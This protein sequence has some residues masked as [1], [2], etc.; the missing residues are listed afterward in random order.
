MARASAGSDFPPPESKRTRATSRAGTSTTDSPSVSS[1]WLRPWPRPRA[2]ST[3][4]RRSGHCRAQRSSR[5]CARASTRSWPSSR[6]AGSTARAVCEDL[7]GSTAIK[8]MKALPVVA[9]L[10]W[11]ERWTGRLREHPHASVESHRGR[12]VA[13]DTPPQSQSCS[14]ARQQNLG[15]QPTSVLNT[16]G[17]QPPVSGRIQTSRQNLMRPTDT[18]DANLPAPACCRL[19]GSASAAPAC[20]PPESRAPMTD[21]AASRFGAGRTHQAPASDAVR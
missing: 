13:G 8:I 9:E 12:T 11:G 1:H 21:A 3:A 16:L 4:Q 15:G 5:L 6:P 14:A 10:R 20:V 7:W 2:P 18:H 17:P 19:A